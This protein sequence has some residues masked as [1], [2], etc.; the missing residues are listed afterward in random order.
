ML[1]RANVGGPVH[2]VR[3]LERELPALGVRSSLLLGRVGGCEGDATGLLS[4]AGITYRVVPGL[5]RSVRPFDDARAFAWL[6]RTFR[7]EKPDV[8]HTHTGK[9]GL[10]GRLAARF[11]KVPAVVHTHHGHLFRGYWGSARSTGMLALERALAR[12]TD[13]LFVPGEPLRDELIALRLAPAERIVAYPPAIDLDG[14]PASAEAGRAVRGRLGVSEADVVVGTVGRLVAV[15]GVDR[16][17]RAASKGGWTLAVAG[18][19]PERRR[20]EELARSLGARVTFA[21]ETSDP[22]AFLAALDVFA[23]GSRNEGLPA[24][25]LEAMGSGLACVVPAVGSIP[26]LIQPGVTG[27]LYDAP[28]DAALS[29]A[30][31]AVIGDA[32]LRETLGR[33]ATRAVRRIVDPRAMAAVVADGYARALASRRSLERARR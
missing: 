23:L 2:H 6:V 24:A 27:L 9:A 17:V 8:V 33:A 14:F 12:R 26:E 16:L 4:A 5:R 30:I 7:R 3:I 29:R 28:D 21:G 32:A 13:L 31:D 10:I 18:G 11:A 20:L 15:K 22:A 1:T 19:G 25:L